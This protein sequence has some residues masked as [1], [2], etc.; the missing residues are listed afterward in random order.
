MKYDTRDKDENPVN[1]ET[2]TS[3]NKEGLP[4][5][6]LN[7]I[8]EESLKFNELKEKVKGEQNPIYYMRVE[9]Y[10]NYLT[11]RQNELSKQPKQQKKTS[12]VWQGNADKE[13]PELYKLMIESH[14][15]AKETTYQ[16][17]K[18]V[19]TGQPIDDIEKIRK[20]KKFT[21][22]L[23]TYFISELFQ[24]S[25]PNDYLSIAE[26]CFDGAK[27]LSQAQTNYTN[28]QKSLPKNHIIIDDL[29]KDLK[30]L[31]STLH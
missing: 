1:R 10:L 20:T 9:T 3:K 19:F 24:K 23:L 14:L 21:N 5:T 8:R 15:I 22:V 11:N 25:N 27:N 4:L 26:S 7:F 18:A 16:Q 29:L 2:F 28:N 13:L 6:E 31:C 12:Y 17:F 30:N